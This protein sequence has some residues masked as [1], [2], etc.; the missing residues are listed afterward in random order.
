MDFNRNLREDQKIVQVDMVNVNYNVKKMENLIEEEIEG[1]N[2]V[3]EIKVE[4]VNY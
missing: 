4:I 2:K 1:E 3:L